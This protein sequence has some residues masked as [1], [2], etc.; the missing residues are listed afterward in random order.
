MPVF[1]C[2]ACNETLKRAKV[3]AHVQKC[4][5]AWIMS[6]MDCNKKFEGDDYWNHTTCVTEAERY[7]G[8][9]YVAKDNKGDVKQAAW[10]SAVQNKLDSAAG[11]G[12]LKPYMETLL[13]YDNIPR[14][15]A[16]FINFAKNSLNLKADREGIAEQLWDVIGFDKEPAPAP[17]AS[18]VCMPCVPSAPAAAEPAAKV[19]PAVEKVVVKDEKVEKREKEEKREK[20]EKK[21]KKK[22]KKEKEAKKEGVQREEEAALEKGG[23]TPEKLTG[24]KR[25]AGNELAE[26]EQKPVKW[27]KIIQKVRSCGSGAGT[28]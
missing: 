10:L 1:V 24:R 22:E 26:G 14:K 18:P 4:R 21:E 20:K 13:K 27:K 3:E 17:A 6:C 5:G 28:P 8:H 16:K 2:E 7:Q 25:K 11:S 23:E 12:K 19:E 15:K 9:L